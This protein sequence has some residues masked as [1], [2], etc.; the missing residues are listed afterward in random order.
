MHTLEACAAAG[1]TDV[2][3]KHML[4]K[5]QWQ[6]HGC[7]KHLCTLSACHMRHVH[8]HNTHQSLAPSANGSGPSA[9]VRSSD[10]NN[11]TPVSSN[12]SPYRY[13]LMMGVPQSRLTATNISVVTVQH[14]SQCCHY[15]WQPAW[16]AVMQTQE[17]Q[18]RRPRLCL[19]H[20]KHNSGNVC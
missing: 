18:R 6:C 16:H 9:R 10:R 1:C 5:H 7:D 8:R 4:C 20:G 13:L 11:K 19:Q 17:Q 14:V 15:M 3:S 2:S 12:L